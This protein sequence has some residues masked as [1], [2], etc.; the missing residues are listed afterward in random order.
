MRIIFISVLLS[1]VC[2]LFEIGFSKF[3]QN[4]M[5]TNRAVELSNRLCIFNFT[6]KSLCVDVTNAMKQLN[7]LQCNLLNQ[8]YLKI[9]HLEAAKFPSDNMFMIFISLEFKLNIQSQ[10]LEITEQFNEFKNYLDS[11]S[12]K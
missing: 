11:I 2:L 8:D 4:K 9:L 7:I 6:Y 3:A 5:T 12:L 10:K 1:F